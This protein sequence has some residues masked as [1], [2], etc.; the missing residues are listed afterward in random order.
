V[1]RREPQCSTEHGVFAAPS[2]YHLSVVTLLKHRLALAALVGVLLIP[3]LTANNG[4]LSHLLFCEAEVSQPFAIAA[5]ESG[6][7]PLVTSSR[8]LDRDTL[9]ENPFE[10]SSAV[11]PVCQGV[12]A[13]LSADPLSN[14]RVL[15]TVTLINESDTTW[16][17]SIG[18]DATGGASNAD[19]TATIGEVGPGE[20]SSATLELRVADGQ[21]ELGGTLL[22]GP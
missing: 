8:A 5:G 17:G 13:E 15:L 19:L 14:G 22:L 20:T 4:G 12:Y 9:E 18:L 11:T 3:L 6:G 21:T 10:G 7:E 2:G 16:R 1:H